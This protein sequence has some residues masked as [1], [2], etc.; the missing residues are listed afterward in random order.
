MQQSTNTKVIIEAIVQSSRMLMRDFGE[1]THLQSTG[2]TAYF[3]AKSLEKLEG[4]LVAELQTARP[5]YTIKG[6]KSEIIGTHAYYRFLINP[7]SGLQNFEHGMDSF[8][9]AV[10]LQKLN[11]AGPETIISVVD[12]PTMHKTIWA[13]KGC[14][15]WV[16]NFSNTQSGNARL[17]VSQRKNHDELMGVMRSNR[18]DLITLVNFNCPIVEICLVAEGKLDFAVY[19]Q[20]N[21][22]DSEVIE[23]IIKESG[24]LVAKG[25]SHIGFG[26]ENTLKILNLHG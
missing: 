25:P 17:R 14:G 3:A 15:A 23:L 1:I 9:I 19:E 12:F 24:G 4:K 18:S 22:I 2:K 26:A 6:A 21:F 11:E 16:H 13:E 7:M 20:L 5:T 10:S 8:A